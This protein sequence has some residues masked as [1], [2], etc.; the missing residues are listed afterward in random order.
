MNAAQHLGLVLLLFLSSCTQEEPQQRASVQG[1]NFTP[2]VA[3]GYLIQHSYYTL[4]YSNTH[5]QAEF[6][7]YYLSPASIQGGQDRTDD[8]RIDP[9][10]KSNPVK[11]T[12]YQGSGYVIWP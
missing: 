1:D 3:Q 6:A 9:K 12:D 2:T 8:F 5:R 4:S 7:S 10:V 11:S